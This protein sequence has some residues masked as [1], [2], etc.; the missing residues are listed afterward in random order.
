[1]RILW[2]TPGFPADEHD[3][4]CIPPLQLLAAELSRRGVDLRVIA[5]EYPFRQTLYT[6]HGIPVFPCNGQNRFRRKPFTLW[7]AVRQGRQLLP[8]KN[9]LLHSFWWGWAAW[10]GDRLGRRSGVPHLVTLMGQDVRPANRFHLSRLR[11]ADAERLVALSRFHQEVLFQ[12]AGIRAA[13]TIPWGVDDAE[14]P[15]HLPAE[16]PLDVLG[17]G[18]LVGVKNWP[19]WLRAVRLALETEPALQAELIGEGPERPALEGL[20][21]AFHLDKNV[22]LAGALPR[23]AVLARMRQAR[24]LLHTADFESFGFVLAE[25]QAQGCR[26]VS[27]PV[28]IGA[29]LDSSGQNEAEL[30]AQLLAALRAPLAQAVHA[31]FTI[32]ETA[33]KYLNIYR[34]M[35][36]HR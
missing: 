33:E 20:I 29:D 22:R 15:S 25:A 23:P 27:T 21:R 34:N 8:E 7:Q 19:L 35:Q 16:R 9:A 10:A 4:N 6:W 5:L 24:I 18:S 26:V 28:G 32:R 3:L 14:T 30:A 36:R 11:P 1:M 31:P 17:V 13:H 2:L 12:T